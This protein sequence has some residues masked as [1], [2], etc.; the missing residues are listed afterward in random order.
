MRFRSIASGSNGNCIYTDTENTRILIDAGISCKRIE[1]GLMEL[2]VSGSALSA[3]LIT[4]EH[5]DHIQGLKILEKHC[6]VPVYGTPGTLRAILDSDRDGV[7]NPAL[8]H[9]IRPGQRFTV[10]DYEILPIRTSHD[11]ADPCAYRLTAENKSVAVIT[12]LGT[13]TEEQAA[14]LQDLSGLLLESNHDIRMLET[15]RYPYVLKRRILSDFGHLSNEMSG[16]L[17]DRLLNPALRFVLLGHLS[18]ENNYPDIALMSVKNEI[19]L[20]DS[21]W[22]SGDFRIEVAGR[23]ESSEI[24]EL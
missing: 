9:G 22:H 8:F 13:W 18:E 3:V 10:G 17:L 24:F 15:G 12:D 21:P 23:Y 4:H 2:G 14:M 19:D 1:Q 20:S 11:A 16:K 7:F 6:H 5:S